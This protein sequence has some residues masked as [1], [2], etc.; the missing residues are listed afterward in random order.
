MRIAK[1]KHPLTPWCDE[2]CLPIR[3]SQAPVKLPRYLCSAECGKRIVGRRIAA[4]DA[5]DAGCL[6][7]ARTI[8]EP[9]AVFIKE[10]K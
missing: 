1:Q 3:A 8:V 6:F 2:G 5:F 10:V 9:A 7:L 4:N